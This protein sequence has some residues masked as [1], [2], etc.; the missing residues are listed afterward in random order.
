MGE[1]ADRHVE[2]RPMDPVHADL[3]LYRAEQR[4]AWLLAEPEDTLR[5]LPSRRHRRHRR[6]TRT[7]RTDRA[8]ITQV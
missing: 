8:Q 4:V 7:A 1:A 3:A 6:L 2:D 5:T